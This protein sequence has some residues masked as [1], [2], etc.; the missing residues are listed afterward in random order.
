MTRTPTL[1]TTPPPRL[2]LA[3]LHGLLALLAPVAP[4]SCCATAPTPRPAEAR[5]A[6]V[7]PMGITGLIDEEPFMR[8][9][10]L[11]ADAAPPLRGVDVELA[12]SRGYLSL[13]AGR[14]APLPAVVVV[15]EWW[16]LNDHVRHWADRLAEEGYA[17][18]AVDLYGGQVAT[19]PEQAMALMRGVDETRAEEILTAAHRFL[20]EDARVTAPRRGV[21]GWCFGGAWALQQAILQPDLD[22]A[23]IYYGRLVTDEAALAGIHASLL[24]VFANRDTS[25]PPAAVDAF[26]TALEHAG[27]S[28]ELHRYDADHAFANPSGARYDA[29]SAADAWSHV[30]AFLARTLRPAPE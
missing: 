21:I 13:P 8:L 28:I 19:T 23:V 15:H 1:D 20:R 5:P 29:T 2:R 9:H 24:G 30:R 11:R 18:L 17:A 14:A 25:I 4:L 3:T 6:A 7:E 12:G 10:Q 26:A 27:K 16:G 22:A